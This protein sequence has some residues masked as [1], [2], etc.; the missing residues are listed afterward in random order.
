MGWADRISQYIPL[1]VMLP[2]AGQGALGIE[3]RKNNS[4]LRD[5]I[6]FIHHQETWMEVAAE[7]TFLKRLEGGCQLPIAAY[8]KKKGNKISMTGLLGSVDGQ[9]IIREEI[10]GCCS[11]AEVIGVSLA[12]RILSRGGKAILE[13]VCRNGPGMYSQR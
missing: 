5:A 12:E 8:A 3:L 13:S 7:R 6:S 4:I 10:E 2:A 11:D 9:L 1:E